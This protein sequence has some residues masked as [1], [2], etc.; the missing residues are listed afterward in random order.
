MD[1]RHTTNVWYRY[2]ALLSSS[3]SPSKKIKNKTKWV[4]F[5]EWISQ[6]KQS[7]LWACILL[8]QK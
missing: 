5:D 1:T 8:A 6:V 7:P 2:I 4:W 3:P